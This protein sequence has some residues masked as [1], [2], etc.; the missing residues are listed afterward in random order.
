M[1]YLVSGSSG[2]VGS[3]LVPFLREKGHEVVRLVRSRKNLP[4][5]ALFWDPSM[6]QI[7]PADFEGFDGVIHLAGKNISSG[8]WTEKYKK[9]LFQSRAR[10]TWLLMQ[11]LSRTKHPPTVV[12]TASAVGIY[13]NRGGEPLTEE[14]PPGEGFLADLCQKWEAATEGIESRGVRTVH[15]RFGLI[16]S[17]K[18]GLL[19]KMLPAFRLGLGA[20]LGSGN[21]VMPWVALED[22]VGALFHLLM[23]EKIEGAVNVVAPQMVTQEEF[24]KELAQALHRP[25]FLRIGATPLKWIHREMAEEMFLTSTYAV[26]QKLQ[27]VGYSFVYPTIEQLIQAQQLS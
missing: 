3:S 21:Q 19:A 18:G 4:S 25:L 13:G 11:A 14:S 24:C 22:V 7:D 10:D 1:R 23:D 16:L 26:P 2:L 15:S 8:F 12:I 9:E 17:K 20:V 27:E 6:G 5:D